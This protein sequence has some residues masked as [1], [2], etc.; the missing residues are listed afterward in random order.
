MHN[1]CPYTKIRVECPKA[2][3]RYT[4]HFVRLVQ[5]SVSPLVSLFNV[6]KCLQSKFKLILMTI[7]ENSIF[8]L[9]FQNRKCNADAA[10]ALEKL[11]N[12]IISYF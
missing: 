1:L 12:K 5:N 2:L 11:N 4:L 10:S 6:F 7:I 9:M 8:I 3:N